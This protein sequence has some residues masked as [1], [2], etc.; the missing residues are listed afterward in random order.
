[1]ERLSHLFD[2]AAKLDSLPSEFK[3]AQFSSH[4]SQL[5]LNSVPW[6]EPKDGGESEIPPPSSSPSPLDF[7]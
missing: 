3:C 4:G 6:I 7:R 5:V 2:S 1:M